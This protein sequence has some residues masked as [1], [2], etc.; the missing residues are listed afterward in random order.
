MIDSGNIQHDYYALLERGQP[1]DLIDL[2]TYWRRCKATNPC[3]EM[4][5]QYYLRVTESVLKKA[6]F[7]P[8]WDSHSR[9]WWASPIL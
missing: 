4:W 2:Y 3:Q 9:Q 5:I 7:K 6:G 1:T 8:T